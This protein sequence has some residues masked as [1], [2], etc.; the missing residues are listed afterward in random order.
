MSVE[1]KTAD[2]L[3]PKKE[4]K[5]PFRKMSVG[6]YFDVRMPEDLV[7]Q[8][9]GDMRAAFV[10]FRSVVSSSAAAFNRR[11]GDGETKIV[12]RKHNPRTLRCWCVDADY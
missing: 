12:V 9:D 8:Y 4:P 1:I 5:Y 2:E 10:K 6:Q 7:E 11:N 3:P